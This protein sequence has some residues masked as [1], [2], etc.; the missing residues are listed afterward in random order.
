MCADDNEPQNLK[1]GR[2][3]SVGPVDFGPSGLELEVAHLLCDL[4]DPTDL[5]PNQVGQRDLI[6]KRAQQS[7]G[8]ENFMSDIFQVPV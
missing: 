1:E 8:L 7:I 4:R 2:R 6:P 3:V 5:T